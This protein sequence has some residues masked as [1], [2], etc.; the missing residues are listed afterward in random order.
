M[1]R[2][3]KEESAPDNSFAR[4]DGPACAT[5]LSLLTV[6]DAEQA[7]VSPSRV[8]LQRATLNAIGPSRDDS[9]RRRALLAL[10][11]LSSDCASAMRLRASMNHGW[12]ESCGQGRS[13][14]LQGWIPNASYISICHLFLIADCGWLPAQPRSEERARAAGTHES[15]LC[16]GCP[17]GALPA[18]SEY[19]FCPCRPSPAGSSNSA[20][21]GPDSRDPRGGRGF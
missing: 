17:D 4:K 20:E 18:V 6:T 3:F 21:T 9:R 16:A 15:C 12:F 2:L 5:S 19:E 10:K 13:I 14:L 7:L 8:S 1:I 11:Q